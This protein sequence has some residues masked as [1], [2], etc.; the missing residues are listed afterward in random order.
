MNKT[1]LSEISSNGKQITQNPEDTVFK[2]F[3][4]DSLSNCCRTSDQP[5]GAW[6]D[7]YEQIF[8]RICYN[9]TASLQCAC[10]RAEK[11]SRNCLIRTG[12]RLL[13]S[14]RRNNAWGGCPWICLA[15]LRFQAGV[16]PPSVTKINKKTQWGSDSRYMRTTRDFSG[17]HMLGRKNHWYS[18]FK[19]KMVLLV[20]R[21][22]LPKMS[23]HEQNMENCRRT[24]AQ[25]AWTTIWSFRERLCVKCFRQISQLN[26]FSPVWSRTCPTTL[27]E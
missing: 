21:N 12:Q 4:N 24:P 20:R 1:V 5:Y 2:V 6:H 9:Q 26:G 23:A 14:S 25:R 10:E 15:K 8:A 19:K 11:R 22:F 13:G 3:I 16:T 17:G 18:M 27:F 7:I